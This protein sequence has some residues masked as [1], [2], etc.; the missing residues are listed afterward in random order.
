MCL[1]SLPSKLKKRGD[2]PRLDCVSPEPFKGE[3]IVFKMPENLSDFESDDDE[4]MFGTK[5]EKTEKNATK[6]VDAA[7]SHKVEDMLE[8]DKDEKP[9]TAALDLNMAAE[10]IDDLLKDDDTCKDDTKSEGEKLVQDIKLEKLDDKD[11]DNDTLM[12][13]IDKRDEFEFPPEDEVKENDKKD[14]ALSDLSLSD[15]EFD[16]ANADWVVLDE[17]NSEDK[18]NKTEDSKAPKTCSKCDTAHKV[19]DRCSYVLRH[20]KPSTQPPRPFKRDRGEYSGVRER[21]VDYRKPRER[22]RT[23]PPELY[24]NPSEYERRTFRSRS[25]RRRPPT[26]PFEREGYE[27]RRDRRSRDID[28]RRIYEKED[29][30]YPRKNC[31]LCGS[32]GHF[33]KNCPDLFCYK[34]DQQGHFAKECQSQKSGKKEKSYPSSQGSSYDASIATHTQ[35][36]YTYSS[37]QQLAPSAPNLMSVP[38]PPLMNPTLSHGVPGTTPTFG[39]QPTYPPTTSDHFPSN[40]AESL[41]SLQPLQLYMSAKMMS[42]PGQ[43]YPKTYVDLLV[44]NV[45][46]ML[47]QANLGLQALLNAFSSKGESFV[48]ALITKELQV[49]AERFPGGVNMP[50]IIHTTIEYLVSQGG[51]QHYPYATQ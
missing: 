14:D 38:P 50:L 46:K 17:D 20:S 39:G 43:S 33:V 5:E 21:Q 34:C 11:S 10:K 2:G 36:S 7:D 48:R 15:D 9:D 1:R 44:T 24:N 37:T 49:Y 47:A 23:L 18:E 29:A 6:E 41:H 35:P 22:V 8:L 13:N 51:V 32:A 19:G 25:P 30:E 28:E 40:Y 3:D 16:Q 27:D 45:G 12:L 31:K 42:M 4:D 26:P